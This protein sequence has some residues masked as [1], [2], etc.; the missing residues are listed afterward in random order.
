M[1]LCMVNDDYITHLNI[2][3]ALKYI[4]SHQIKTIES[5]QLK[6]EI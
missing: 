1:C 6:F 3:A 2:K 4:I 5:I